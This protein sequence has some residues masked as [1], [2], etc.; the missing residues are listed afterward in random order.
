MG[1]EV[2]VEAGVGVGVEVE[3]EVGVGV[4]VEVE[5]GV[6]VG[7]GVE[8]EVEVGVGVE[9]DARSPRRRFPS[10]PRWIGPRRLAAI[11]SRRGVERLDRGRD[12]DVDGEVELGG[13]ARG[14]VLA[15]PLRGGRM[16]RPDGAL[17][18][19]L[20]QRAR[21]L[22]ERPQVDREARD[23]QRVE[24]RLVAP[25]ERGPDALAL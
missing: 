24:E 2:G 13:Q 5:V 15:P 11:P 21:R 20:P 6:G 23:A 1:V 4:E 7:V 9:V 12:V 14:Q 22:P 8:V 19:R 3:V 10:H 16:D 18:A 25:V 17:R